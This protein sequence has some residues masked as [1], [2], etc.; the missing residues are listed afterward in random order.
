VRHLQRVGA[1]P[2][3]LLALAGLTACPA[4][5][6]EQKPARARPTPVATPTPPPPPPPA[7]GPVALRGGTETLPWRVTIEVADATARA[8][9]LV[10]EPTLQAIVVEV[11]RQLDPIRSDGELARFNRTPS[12]RPQPISGPALVVVQTCLELGA[13]TDGA[14][15]I[16]AGPLRALWRDTTSPPDATALEI[17]RARTGLKR[18]Q[19]GKGML[20]KDVVDLEVD[21]SAVIDSVAADAIVAALQERSFESFHVEVGGVAVVVGA[22]RAVSIPGGEGASLTLAAPTGTTTGT[23]MAVAVATA[24]SPPGPIDPRQARPVTHD[25]ERCVVVGPD[26]IVAD[27]LAEACLVVGPDGMAKT[28]RAFPG[29]EAQWQ[30]RGGE[31]GA[32]PGFPR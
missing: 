15:D 5:P 19:V 1:L 30:R 22:G 16:T 27:G 3:L 29:I 12:R 31:R 21:A 25:L 9:A 2:A 13:R 24:P 14:F 10:L 6:A 8:R 17:A 28:L 23:T 32:T 20:K 7:T 26:V 4:G 11:G 18:V